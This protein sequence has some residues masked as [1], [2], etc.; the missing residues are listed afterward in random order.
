LWGDVPQA[1]DRALRELRCI[2]Y[3]LKKLKSISN[4][5]SGSEAIIEERDVNLVSPN[6]VDE[7]RE[8]ADRALLQ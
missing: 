1:P 3:E 5:P 8:Q 7:L 4:V 6:G 2:K